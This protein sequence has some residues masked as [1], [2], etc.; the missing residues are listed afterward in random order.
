LVLLYVTSPVGMAQTATITMLSAFSP[1][2]RRNTQSLLPTR[3]CHFRR[4]Q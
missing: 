2:C 3:A 4:A 1:D